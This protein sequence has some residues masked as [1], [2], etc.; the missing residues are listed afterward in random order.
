M[1]KNYKYLI[2]AVITTIAI[3]IIYAAKKAVVDY[4]NDAVKAALDEVKSFQK[5]IAIG[6]QNNVIIRH[7]NVFIRSQRIIK[8]SKDIEKQIE[9]SRDIKQ[10]IAIKNMLMDEI[11][12]RINNFN[13]ENICSKNTR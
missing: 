4:K 10:K 7:H 3:R 6:E 13:D 5:D 9:V 1:I 12:C 11:N 2:Y 8:E